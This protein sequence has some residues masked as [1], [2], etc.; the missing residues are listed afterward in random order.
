MELERNG[1]GVWVAAPAGRPGNASARL[2][3]RMPRGYR[4]QHE[5]AHKIAL[6]L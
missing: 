2:F 1:V 3:L 6:S 4:Y 5:I